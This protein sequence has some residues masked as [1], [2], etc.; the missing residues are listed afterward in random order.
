MLDYASIQPESLPFVVIEAK[1][2]LPTEPCIYFAIDRFGVVQYIGKSVN[3]KRRWGNHHRYDELSEIGS[4]RIAYLYVD[5]DLLN[6]VEAAL[7]KQFKPQLN[8]KSVCGEKQSAGMAKSVVMRIPEP[9]AEDIQRIVDN[10]RQREAWEVYQAKARVAKTVSR[11]EFQ[12]F[13]GGQKDED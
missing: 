10:Y 3:P 6:E 13:E 11:Q 7:I 9:I 1:A 12:E 5:A 2:N 4:I 8:R